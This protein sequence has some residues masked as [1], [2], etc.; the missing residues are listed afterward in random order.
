MDNDNPVVVIVALILMKT[1]K[2]VF[3]TAFSGGFYHF[4]IDEKQMKC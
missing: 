2:M 1:L 3:K 4:G